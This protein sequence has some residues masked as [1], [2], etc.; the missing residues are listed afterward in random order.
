VS[1]R[2]FRELS[3]RGQLLRLRALALDAL[4]EYELEVRRCSFVSTGFNTVF[5]VDTTNG[6]A[7]ALRVSPSLR[8]HA[9]GCELVEG[10]WVAAIR[11]GTDVPTPRM[12]AARNGSLVVWVERDGVPGAR[13]CVLFE[14]VPGRPLRDRPAADPVRRTGA[15]TATLHEHGAGYALARP[16]GALLADR[17]LYFRVETRLDELR[18]TYGSVLEDAVAR[19]QLVLDRLWRDPPHPPHLLHG[20]IQP[21]NVMVRGAAVAIIDFQDLIWGFEA[22]DVG[23]A[24][25]S[26]AHFDGAGPLSAGPL[27]D[28][29]RAGYEAVRAW[30]E[31]DRETWE[32]LRAAR[33]LNIL[34]FGLSRRGPDLDR[35]I[36]RHAGPIAEWMRSR[37]G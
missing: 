10:A 12:I 25:G 28:A 35:F 11:D 1:P 19:A 34:N 5:R 17:V 16:P 4:M 6:D 31:A 15:L 37:N 14:W 9:E 27:R 22:Q 24:L 13:S 26:L 7:Y 20:D 8:I 36:A 18:P 33:H 2:P 3:P 23:I 30:P 21:G 32:A 29:F